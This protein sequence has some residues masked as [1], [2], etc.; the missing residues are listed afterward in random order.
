[1]WFVT[2][3]AYSNKYLKAAAYENL[4][5]VVKKRIQLKGNYFEVP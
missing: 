3:K 1:M 5:Q 4:I 2:S